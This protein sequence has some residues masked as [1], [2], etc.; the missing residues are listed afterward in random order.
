MG[1]LLNLDARQFLVVVGCRLLREE[2]VSFVLCT[3]L[4]F[5]GV[6]AFSFYSF[7]FWLSMLESCSHF[8]SILN[9]DCCVICS[10]ILV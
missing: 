7:S 2:L 3:A 1:F 6:L 8:L 10:L 9:G 5:G 4:F